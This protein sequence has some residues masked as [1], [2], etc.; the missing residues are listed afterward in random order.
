MISLLIVMEIKL[1]ILFLKLS[2][3]LGKKVRKD[4]KVKED[5]LLFMLKP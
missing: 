5:S 1:L 3:I 2:I 4:N